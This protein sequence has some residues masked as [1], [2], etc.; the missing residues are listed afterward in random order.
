MA[1]VILPAYQPDET[2]IRLVKKLWVRG[3][4]IVVVDDGS[5]EAYDR[6][7]EAVKNN[8]VVLKHEV[9][10]GKGAA[11]KTALAYIKNE[12]WDCETV[13]VMDAD[14]Q[15]RVED[16]DVLMQEAG[17][18]RNTLVLG[19]R[20]VGRE[21]PF[22]SR[23]GNTLTREIF[24]LLSGVRVSDTQTGLRAFGAELIP[25]LRE[26]EGSRYEYEMNVLLAAAR[27]H[28]PI[29]E[30]EIATIYHD[31]SNSCSHF[32]VLW[33]SLRIYKDMLKFTAVSVMSFLIDYLLFTIGMFFCPHTPLMLVTVNVVARILSAVYNYSLNCCF[34]FHEHRKKETAAGYLLLAVCIL[35]LNSLLLNVYVQLLPVSVYTAKILTESSLFIISFLV[36]RHW[37]FG[38]HSH[39]GVKEKKVRIGV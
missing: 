38:N 36:Q 28:L 35:A 5:G 27:E 22:R 12:M 24:F 25:R 2:L 30:V 4:S 16:L 13:G 18:H 17:A 9:N 7:F 23:F 33:D 15:H 37:I 6:I 11:I 29:R 31:R 8:A 19:V 34:V 39:L 1:A 14:G 20:K 10:R 21:M 3:Y 26:V 32:R